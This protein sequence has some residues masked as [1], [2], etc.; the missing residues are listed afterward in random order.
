MT[1]GG[2]CP[3][4]AAERA[5]WVEYRGPLGAEYDTQ[6]GYIVLNQDPVDLQSV[7]AQR[8]RR[9]VLNQVGLIEKICAA[10]DSCGAALTTKENEA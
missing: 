9:L 2:L 8:R 1:R 4:H 7:A 10:G 5:Q 6:A 3:K